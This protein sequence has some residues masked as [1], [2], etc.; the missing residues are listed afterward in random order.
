MA[1][2]PTLLVKLDEAGGAPKAPTYITKFTIPGDPNYLAAT[3]TPNFTAVLLGSYSRRYTVLDV[4]G[5]ALAD[6]S[7]N[8]FAHARY[9]QPTDTLFLHTVADGV[10]LADGDYSTGGAQEDLTLHLTVFAD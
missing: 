8:L 4:I 5:V 2:D 9:D 1:L 10:P 3:G 6:A 7:G